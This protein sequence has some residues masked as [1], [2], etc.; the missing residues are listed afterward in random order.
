[1]KMIIE[2]RVSPAASKPLTGLRSDVDRIPHP[3]AF[4]PILNPSQP[5][6]CSSPPS[7]PGFLVL[8]ALLRAL[9]LASLASLLVAGG[10][11]SRLQLPLV[12]FST[13]ATAGAS[14]T[15]IP[16]VARSSSSF[17]SSGSVSA[18]QDG[19]TS[20]DECS[21]AQLTNITDLYMAAADTSACEDYMSKLSLSIYAP[22]SATDCIQVISEL[23]AE[24]PACLYEGENLKEE[25]MAAL[26]SCG[27]TTVDASGSSGQDANSSGS[28]TQYTDIPVVTK[29]AASYS[30]SGEC[31]AAEIQDISYAYLSAASSDACASYSTITTSYVDIDP[32]CSATAC[33]Q[34]IADMVR[35]LPDCD[36]EGVNYK[37]SLTAGL[38]S[39]GVS[40]N[41][42]SS[43]S[44]I[45]GST[46]SDSS[47]SAAA[48]STGWAV[49]A[50]GG[51]AAVLVTVML[52]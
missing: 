49:T 39:C 12:S 1:M 37:T 22:C 11:C 51:A 10:A 44:T 3:P 34:E 41:G 42:S 21:N 18:S 43:G 16:L 25:L 28:G 31:S 38:E 19:S 52:M 36:Y 33:L 35:G 13:A 5:P 32:P 9:S 47:S 14:Y 17:S 48:A 27:S 6:H 46:A 40:V 20:G 45:V 23:A 8:M 15:D 26:D 7:L 24:M 4:L 29:A 2:A 50:V 30:D